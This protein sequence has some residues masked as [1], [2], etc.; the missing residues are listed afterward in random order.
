[1]TDWSSGIV[2]VDGARLR[3]HRT[4]G[5]KPPIVMAHGLTDNGLCWTRVARDLEQNYDLVMYDARGHGQSTPASVDDPLDVSAT[6]LIALTRSLG[7]DRPHL[8]GHSMGAVTVAVAAALEPS[9]CRSVV[10]VDPPLRVDEGGTMDD[11]EP[12]VGNEWW[13]QW[14]QSVAEERTLPRPE[15][16]AACQARRPGW[17]A[18]EQECWVSAHREVDPIVFDV[19][20]PMHGPWEREASRIES[21]VLFVTGEPKL[22]AL[23]D[24]SAAAELMRSV[25]HGRLVRIRGAGHSVHRDR[26]DDFMAEVCAFLARVAADAD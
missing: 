11:I 2:E 18:I 9:V 26:Y 19:R 16:L 10:L 4:G 1:M 21:P 3:Y 17:A 22:G 7:L 6:D 8:I 12:L 23:A 14:R 13:D 5:N 15:L 24:P 25:A 20:Y